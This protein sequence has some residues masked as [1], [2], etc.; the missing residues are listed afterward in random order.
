MELSRG[1]CLEL[2]EL[3]ET[4]ASVFFPTLQNC[5]QHIPDYKL[6]QFP[7]LNINIIYVIYIYIYIYLK[8]L[9]YSLNTISGET[10]RERTIHLKIN[11]LK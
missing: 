5:L 4:F 7:F 10:L 3:T 11:T 2:T 6:A 9:E 8:H 1:K